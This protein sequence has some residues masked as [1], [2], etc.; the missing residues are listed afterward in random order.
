[1]I[2]R[3]F[4]DVS[5]YSELI[6][7]V[8]FI[9]MHGSGKA[10]GVPW[11]NELAYLLRPGINVS[12]HYYINKSGGIYQLVP[13]NATAWHAGSSAW[14]DYTGLNRFSIGVCLES[15]NG[16]EE[17][18]PEAQRV[19]AEQLVRDLMD[20]FGV[21]AGNVLSHKEISV[22]AGRKVDPVNFDMHSFRELLSRPPVTRLPAY[23]PDT[24]ELLGEV[25][26]ITDST[27]KAVKVYP[28]W[29]KGQPQRS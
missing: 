24:N 6:P 4:T 17:E 29:L 13:H 20:E 1:M 14:G 15:S 8:R 19:A 11:A 10:P 9:I 23:H 22:P 28:A 12:Y 2:N 3:R 5:N 16:F 26:V 27:G 7:S 21:P 25:T 18:Y